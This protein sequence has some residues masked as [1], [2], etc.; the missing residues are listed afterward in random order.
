MSVTFFTT[1]TDA[2]LDKE[3]RRL[4]AEGFGWEDIVVLTGIHKFAAQLVVSFTELKRLER[5]KDAK[6]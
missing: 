3:C 4:A 2:E 1:R 6:P 5:M